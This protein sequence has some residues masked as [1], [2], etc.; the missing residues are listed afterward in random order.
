MEWLTFFYANFPFLQSFPFIL[1][2]VFLFFTWSG[3]NTLLSTSICFQCICRCVS[4][5]VCVLFFYLGIFIIILVCIL[6]LLFGF[7]FYFAC[8]FELNI[9]LFCYSLGSCIFYWNDIEIELGWP[10][11]MKTDSNRVHIFEYLFHE[12]MQCRVY[13]TFHFVVFVIQSLFLFIFYF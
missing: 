9:F 13:F 11:T 4:V 6:S 3:P 5:Y 1:P 2:S 10:W 7:G 8:F 12:I